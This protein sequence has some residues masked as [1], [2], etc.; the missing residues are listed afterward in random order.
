M[1][2]R[3]LLNG[4]ISSDI[5]KPLKTKSKQSHKDLSGVNKLRSNVKNIYFFRKDAKHICEIM[6]TFVRRDSKYEKLSPGTF[7]GNIIFKYSGTQM[8]FNTRIIHELLARLFL[9]ILF[10]YLEWQKPFQ[11]VIHK[12]ELWLYSNPTTSSYISGAQLWI[13]IVFPLPFLPI[14]YHVIANTKK[15][16]PNLFKSDLVS[17][18]LAITLLLPLNGVITDLIKNAVGR[19]RPDFAYR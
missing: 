3:Y 15:T 1:T 4:S 2:R 10:L 6:K 14:V 11:R 16:K 5:S 19:P 18:T 9:L 13:F 8:F 12:E 7:L 17:S